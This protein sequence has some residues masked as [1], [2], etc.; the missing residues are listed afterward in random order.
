MDTTFAARGTADLLGFPPSTVLRWC[1]EETCEAFK[2][3]SGRWRLQARTVARLVS[4]HGAVP[5]PHPAGMTRNDLLVLA[6]LSRAPRGLVSARAAAAVTGTSPT[7]ASGVLVGLSDR[8]LALR[9]TEA[10]TV[11]GRSRD[12]DIWYAELDATRML[13]LL[14]YLHRVELPEVPSILTDRLPDQLWQLFWNA[15]PT[16]VDPVSDAAVIAYRAMTANDPEA[17]GWAVTA[18]PVEAWR[19]ALTYRGLRSDDI[20]WLRAGQTLRAAHAAG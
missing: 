10:R 6:A 5:L 3:A 17:L 19:T 20:A 4:I 18:L 15:R 11:R 14:P 2:E 9:R 16:D 13:T 1:R 7:T 12:M 8:G